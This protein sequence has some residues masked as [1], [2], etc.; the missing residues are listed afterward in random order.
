MD[1]VMRRAVMAGVIGNALE[2]YDFA[3]YGH[4]SVVIGRQFFPPEDATTATL[5]AFAVFSVSFFLRPVGA[6]IFSLI[7]DRL[8][9]KRALSISILGMAIPTAC[10][11]I[12][13][14]YGQLGLMAT[15][16]LILLRLLQG[17][18]MGGEMGG[19]V[20][21]VMEHVAP[22]RKGLVSAMIQA[23]TCL[24]LL[25]GALVSVLVSMLMTESQFDE[26]GWR[27]PFIL[28]LLAA[29]VGW[30]IRIHMPESDHFEEVRLSGQLL[31]NPV[32]QVMARYRPALAIGLMWLMP[33]TSCFYLG[34]V[35]FNSFMIGHLGYSSR[36]AL[37]MTSLAL[38]ISGLVTLLCGWLS[39]RW[40]TMRSLALGSG[41]MVF[42]VQPLIAQL[43]GENGTEAMWASYLLFAA[44][45]GGYTSVVFTR[46]AELFPTEVRYSGVSL[47]L[48]IASPLFGSTVPLLAVW[49]VSKYGA[50]F[51]FQLLGSYVMLMA[52]AAALGVRAYYRYLH[53][54][55][56][57][58][59]DQSPV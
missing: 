3:L 46:V 30:R 12:L 41:L 58:A 55:S 35:Y 7:G 29:W 4:F 51:G 6:V 1:G 15:L 2:W 5:A 18:A 14:S 16:L 20:T 38:T 37:M 23:S 25:S 21:Y 32:K 34:F 47:V 17:I 36:H 27:I 52:G 54:P 28:G 33:M 43:S 39:D 31:D 8:G 49:L 40:C 53:K 11:G 10:I 22:N 26:W 57:L 42:F 19:A 56:E 24:G 44:L 45:I 13:P 50:G 59:L 48:N 9:R